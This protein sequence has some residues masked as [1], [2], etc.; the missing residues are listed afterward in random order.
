MAKI[1]FFVVAFRKKPP[2][3]N[4][5]KIT[6][7]KNSRFGFQPA[8]DIHTDVHPVQAADPAYF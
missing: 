6:I 5:D 8:G 4:A 2:S 3:V 1:T 7:T